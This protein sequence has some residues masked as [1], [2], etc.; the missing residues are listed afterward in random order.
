MNVR[1]NIDLNKIKRE[2]EQYHF[3]V[4]IFQANT[5]RAKVSHKKSSFLEIKKLSAKTGV[6][7]YRQMFRTPTETSKTTNAQLFEY[8]RQ[9][10]RDYLADCF[11]AMN[12]RTGN[13]TKIHNIF[14]SLVFQSNNLNMQQACQAL[15][16]MVREFIE[17]N[18]YGMHNAPATIKQKH[19][20]K[21]F[22]DSRQAQMSVRARFVS[23]QTVIEQSS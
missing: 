18:P 15:V 10:G 19:Q 20:D 6:S 1:M 16:A 5:A 17:S 4:G 12:N 8:E 22:I 7:S 13:V 9:K 2:V 21:W 23:K 14:K 3:Q 11:S